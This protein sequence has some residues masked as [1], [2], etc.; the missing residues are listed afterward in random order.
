MQGKIF[1]KMGKRG[2]KYFMP[3]LPE[4]SVHEEVFLHV[5]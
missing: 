1:I 4:K 5:W 2:N 3:V